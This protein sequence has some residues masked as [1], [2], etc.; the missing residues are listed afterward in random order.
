VVQR[1]GDGVECFLLCQSARERTPVPPV[2]CLT[3]RLARSITDAMKFIDTQIVDAENRLN[4]IARKIE[5]LKAEALSVRG[6][7]RAYHIVKENQPDTLP[8]EI[9]RTEARGAATPQSVARDVSLSVKVSVE[10]ERVGFS[11]LT[12]IWRFLFSEM[13][14]AY[15]KAFTQE[16]L[17]T[18]A[19]E[20]GLE[21]GPSFR[22]ALWHHAVRN[23]LVRNFDDTFVAN[24]MTAKKA[25]VRWVG[26]TGVPHDHGG[27]LASSVPTGTMKASI[28]NLVKDSKGLTA[29]QIV[30]V[31]GAKETTVRGTLWQLRKVGRLESRDGRWF[32]SES[33]KIGTE[34]LLGGTVPN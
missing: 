22:T 12:L 7:L 5:E 32:A 6:E 11:R 10:P 2:P 34:P 18:I 17:A 3:E 27:T 9:K 28:E 8:T 30:E 15:P 29:A 16:E 14:K 26:E 23:N 21:L 4:E 13:V 25:G 19:R 1:H 20:K 33:E 24:E 31:T